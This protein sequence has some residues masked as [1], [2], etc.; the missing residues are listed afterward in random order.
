M[1]MTWQYVAGFFDGEG[2]VTTYAN[3]ARPNHFN[4]RVIF[5]QSKE[6]GKDLLKEIQLFLSEHR[7]KS[8]L[9][10]GYDKRNMWNLDICDRRGIETFL[11]TCLPLFRIKKTVAQDTWRFLRLYP[12]LV[13][14]HFKELNAERAK[15]DWYSKH[16]KQ[17]SGPG[18]HQ[19]S[20]TQE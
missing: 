11:L 14:Q 20:H 6:R 17:H 9:H 2:C 13:G 7:I 4:T 18:R 10:G 12:T 1:N 3:C 5:S 15:G 16:W 8:Y 19:A